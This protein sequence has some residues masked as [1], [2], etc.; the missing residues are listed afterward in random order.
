M[1]SDPRSD[2]SPTPAVED[3]AKKTGL[4]IIFTEPLVFL[5]PRDIYH[6]PNSTTTS[7]DPGPPSLVR[8]LLTLTLAKPTRIS[9]ISLELT[10]VTRN[11]WPEGQ[12]SD[13]SPRASIEADAGVVGSRKM[14]PPEERTVYRAEAVYF[15]GSSPLMLRRSMSLVDPPLRLL[16]GEAPAS[17]NVPTSTAHYN[18]PQMNA[19][20]GFSSERANQQREPVALFET[21]TSIASPPVT[22]GEEAPLYSLAYTDA[23]PTT[24]GSPQS[25]QSPSSASPT[26]PGR[27]PTTPR[28]DDGV[29]RGRRLSGFRLYSLLGASRKS[30]RDNQA[31]DAG[32]G[33]W[34]EF[35]AG[36]WQFRATC[37]L[38]ADI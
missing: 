11:T 28:D 35:K 7:T 30:S 4:T 26:R 1:S 2:S 3:R 21:E 27:T 14:V 36:A 9:R 5:R 37:C 13:A 31:V 29:N 24:S 33:E 32:S 15:D 19:R 10:C 16:R 8:G 12:S 22:P 20:R 23:P 18:Q 38:G 6:Q 34:K 17:P 25:A